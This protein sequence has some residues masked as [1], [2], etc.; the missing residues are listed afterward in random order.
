MHVFVQMEKDWL[1][2]RGL[3]PCVAVAHT[4]VPS[5]TA[6]TIIW[7]GYG[8]DR[9]YTLS[10][11]KIMWTYSQKLAF[12][13]HLCLLKLWHLM[14]YCPSF[15]SNILINSHSPNDSII[16][17]SSHISCT[18]SPLCSQRLRN[19][20][21]ASRFQLNIHV[22]I[23]VVRQ[24]MKEHYISCLVSYQHIPLHAW[25]LFSSSLGK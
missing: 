15:Y 17:D 5:R 25:Y 2:I 7:W 19:L 9:S 22:A 11:N 1:L 6:V 8:G 23:N 21:Y 16:T 3:L 12:F 10:H 18:N 14:G 4:S 20:G 24:V 13:H